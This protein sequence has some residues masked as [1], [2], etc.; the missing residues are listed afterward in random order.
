MERAFSPWRNCGLASGAL[1]QAGMLRAFGPDVEIL[2][3]G[4]SVLDGIGAKGNRS[5][6]R[7]EIKMEEHIKKPMNSQNSSLL[8]GDKGR[9]QLR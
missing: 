8:K 7:H 1:R 4:P 9:K 6:I 5:W 2:N 3:P